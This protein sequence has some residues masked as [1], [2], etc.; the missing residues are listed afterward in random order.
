M[1]ELGKKIGQRALL[2]LLLAVTWMMVTHFADAQD[3]HIYVSPRGSD[4]AAGAI[5]AP[6]ASLRKGIELINQS[7]EKNVV[8]EIRGGTY[9]LDTTIVITPA[10][11]GS[12]T[13]SIRNYKNEAVTLSARTSIKLS[14]KKF[15]DNIYV[16]EAGKGLCIDRLFVNNRQLHMARYPDYDSSARVFNGTAGDVVAPARIAGWKQPA[17]AYFHA[18]HEG[19]WGDFHYIIKGVDS[20][21]EA[22]LEGG[23]QNNRPS[24]LHKKLRFVE[25][26]FEELNT[27]NEWFYDRSSGLLYF[28][29]SSLQDLDQQFSYSTLNDLLVIRGDMNTPV[30]NVRVQGIHFT[31][32]NRT[33]MLTKEPLLRTDWTIYRGGA[34]LLDGT[35]NVRI[36]NC[37]FSSL[38]GNAVF[39]SNYNRKVRISGN[40]I[41]DIGASG[42]ALIGSPNAVRSP[43][44]QYSQF[45]PYNEQD[46]H[47]GPKT[48]E[49]P[50]EC[51][52]DNN[53]VHDIGTV[54]KQVSAVVIDMSSRIKISHNSIYNTPRAG[55]N[56][57]DGCWGGHIL[58]Y[59]DVFNTVLET[60][61]HGAFNSWGRDRFWLPNGG[62]VDSMVALNPK[63][64]FLDVVE[65]ITLRNNR[66]QCAHGWDI[67]LDDGSS[68]YR[69]YNNLCLEGGIKLREGYNREVR[70]NVLVNN[71]FHPHVWFRNS[72]D[73]F[74]NN[75]IS[76]DYAPIS[77]SDWGN[78]VDS[79]FFLQQVSLNAARANGTDLHS[80]YGDPK[81][82]NPALNDYRVQNGSPAMKSGFRNFPMDNFGVTA[83]HLVKIA[84]QPPAPGIKIYALKEKG[85]TSEF[86]GAV[87]KNIEGLGERSAAGLPDEDGILL[88]S[89]SNGSLADSSGLKPRDVIRKINGKPVRD[90]V[91]LIATMQVE[92]WHGEAEATI[93]RDQV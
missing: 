68:N 55:I 3:R 27:R 10:M 42:I 24:P 88:I 61:D 59:N 75:I 92:T 90:M 70:N 79:N 67:D 65:P 33:F 31:G 72:G 5:N 17:G 51:V 62:T 82:V 8:I 12:H 45:V 49:Y 52:V 36:E 83:S 60:G 76:A 58:E 1:G 85:R 57:G 50:L 7:S 15:R 35:E 6:I 93:V 69:L 38:G 77:I 48:P 47:P 32:T 30:R 23:W 89:V 2:R 21:G 9:Q 63:L 66:F 20:S 74:A 11:I 25:N 13:V 91:E 26:V 84:Q 64:P 80:Q 4:N 18:L 19:E 73:V 41:Y 53:L 22:I 87:I 71:S 34:I 56:I 43:S 81:F 37:V 54:E 28:I 29:P 78:R 16:A 44:F 86:L 46:Q 40:H 14:W 39:V